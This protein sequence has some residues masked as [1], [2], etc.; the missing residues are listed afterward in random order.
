M[1]LDEIEFPVIPS[2]IKMDIEGTE[3]NALLG[4]IKL[5]RKYKPA[6]AICIYHRPEDIYDIIKLINSWNLGY[7][8]E[9]RVYEDVGVDL[10]LYAV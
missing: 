7:K 5:I 2:Y 3:Y 6:L 10:V 4:A 9:M 8:F 1:S